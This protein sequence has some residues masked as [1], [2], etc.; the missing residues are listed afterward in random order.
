MILVIFTLKTNHLI[1]HLTTHH[2]IL[3]TLNLFLFPESIMEAC[4]AVVLPTNE[5]VDK[6]LWCDHSN[7]TSGS[8]FA[9]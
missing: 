2:R 6:I 5:S 9:W 4:R 1:Q 3:R 7:E 8:T